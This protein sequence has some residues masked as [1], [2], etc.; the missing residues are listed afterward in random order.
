MQLYIK[1]LTFLIN[2]SLKQG[3]FPDDLKL[4]K[5][6]PI[7]KSGSTTTLSNYRP[8]SVLNYFSKIFEKVVYNKVI[9][10]LDEY[11][12]LVDNQFGFRQGHSTHHALIT[13]VDK[14]TKCMDNG[15]LV[16]G[17]FLDLKKCFDTVDHDILIKKLYAYGIR[18][19]LCNWFKSYLSD[20]SQYV[21]YDGEESDIKPITCGVPQ[22]SIL[23]P[24]LFLIF[25]NDFANASKTLYYVLF[26]DDT[27]VFL[28]GKDIHVLVDQ[29]QS[30]LLKLSIWLQ[31]NKLTLN[32]DKTQYMVFHRAK[33]K[34]FDI[35]IKIND[36]VIEQVI[37]T[38][39]LGVIIDNRLDWTNHISYISSK[40]SKGI[41]IICRARKFFTKA[42]LTTL[43]NSFIFPY[44]I[45]GVEVWGHA[46]NTYL[47]QLIKIQK[48]I[49]R[50]ITNSHYMAHTKELFTKMAILPF[51][52]LVKHRVGL[53]MYKISKGNV[54]RPLK[55][56]YTCN[57]DV[58]SYNTRQKHHF[59]PIKANHEFSYRTFVAQSIYIW[60]NITQ[61]L[62][63]DV[64]FT[65][66]KKSLKIYLS[67]NSLVL[68]YPK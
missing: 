40:L 59:R 53:L 65:I 12:I 63:T 4:A 34:T 26:A 67:N 5:V 20:R 60:N 62:N 22:G 13:L 33:R 29:I 47:Q 35:N 31:A 52:T 32:L 55:T 39:F 66:F 17:I 61:N 56:L 8:I 68:R 21:L 30:E 43:Y 49:I 58:H 14:I 2:S 54:P 11:N 15:D 36:C 64:S 45:Y 10:F 7:Y 48:K 1:P 25:I 23:G 50:I 41:G 24:L 18:G 38:K 16:I 9:N 57:K 6:L 19:T 3:I 28:A 37:Y 51:D 46:S 42:A 27:N 44:F